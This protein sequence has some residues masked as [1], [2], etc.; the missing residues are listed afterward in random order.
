[1]MKLFAPLSNKRLPIILAILFLLLLN[2]Y[3]VWGL[4]SYPL[5]R[6]LLNFI[7]P[8]LF[9]FS[10]EKKE[11]KTPV[12]IYLLATFLYVFIAFA[13][14]RAS[15]IG[16]ITSSICFLYVF[17]FWANR[18][19]L[20]DVLEQLIN[21]L[22]VIV[23]IAVIAWILY[24]FGFLSPIGEIVPPMRDDTTYSVYPF[25]VISNN[26]FEFDS[27]FRFCGPFTEPGFLGTLVALILVAKK[28]NLKDIRLIAL[29]VSGLLSL[30][31][32]FYLI[33][34]FFAL[35]YLAVEKRKIIP[36]LLLVG[37]AGAFYIYTKDDPILSATIYE[38]VAWDSDSDN[39]AG[40]NRTNDAT[41]QYYKKI[42]GTGAFYLG[43][44]DPNWYQ[45]VAGAGTSYKTAI[46]INGFIIVA[47]YLLYLLQ[48][49]WVNKRNLAGFILFAAVLLM[50]FYQRPSLYS[51]PVLFLY[52]CMAKAD[53]PYVRN[54]ADKPSYMLKANTQ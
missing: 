4:S 45:N 24:L 8:V 9:C 39:I 6:I 28:F 22:F 44:S 10:K 14:G 51:L 11:K 38:R 49:G 5:F 35:F 30:S 26:I 48:L 17:V 50:N 34:A 7:I 19:L 2:P 15:I 33:S 20:F 1:M 3:Y 54:K 31:L 13:I 41:E 27:V 25:F 12:L 37:L 46:C 36:V 32:A 53:K 16:S 43:T 47:L 52:C 29:F 23:G 42:K 18:E 40:D 21:L